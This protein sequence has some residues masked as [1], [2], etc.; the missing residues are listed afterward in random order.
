MDCYTFENH[1]SEYIDGELKV[2]VRKSFTE[3]KSNCILCKEK[4]EDIMQMVKSLPS[5]EKLETSSQFMN[6][7]QH[8]IDTYEDKSIRR[9]K[10]FFGL[11]NTSLIGL[12]AAM[13][14]MIGSSYL[15]LT[16]D[17]VPVVDLDKISTKN[18]QTLQQPQI[19][20]DPQH[21]FIADKDS[22]KEEDEEQYNMPIRLVG[23]S[24]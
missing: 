15:L 5:L 14:L 1:I 17:S 9:V 2:G 8:K 23:G 3:H 22:S 12:A 16:G 6:N 19:S 7:L 18:S 20:I 13:V 10:L 4:L 24:K 21:S 11:D